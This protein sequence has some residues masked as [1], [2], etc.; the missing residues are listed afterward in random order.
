VQEK[1][2]VSGQH[3]YLQC[4]EGQVWLFDGAPA[5]GVSTNGTFVN[6]VRVP[7]HGSRLQDGDVIVLAALDPENPK[8]DVPGTATLRFIVEDR[9]TADGSD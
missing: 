9:T 3:A 6:G 1:R 4:D 2:L 7:A 8:P 5:G